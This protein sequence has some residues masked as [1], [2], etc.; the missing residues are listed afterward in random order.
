MKADGELAARHEILQAL[1]R[2]GN[3]LDRGDFEGLASI[4]SAD[5]E[6]HIA[7]DPGV[8]SPLVGR[9]A[10]AAEIERRWRV[11]D[12]AEQRRHVMGNMVIESF[13]G[14][15]ATTRTVLTIF[16]VERTPGSA[17]RLHGLGTFDDEFVMEDDR[18]VIR[19]RHLQV[20]RRD[21]FSP[22]WVSAS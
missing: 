2:Y 1:A 7:P 8:E 15:R 5:A 4:F 13:D 16:A 6:F 19:R 17:V 10:I 21:Y 12:A 22:G 20:D 14:T 18:W 3:Y 11:V 9:A